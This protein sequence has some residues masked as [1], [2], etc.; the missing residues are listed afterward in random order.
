MNSY[1]RTAI[2][3]AAGPELPR[4]LNRF[5]GSTVDPDTGCWLWDGATTV[6]YGRIK[7]NS[8]IDMAHRVSYEIFVGPIPEGLQ[9]DHLCRNRACVNPAHLEPVTRR[10][11]ILRGTA[12]TAVNARK[13]HCLNGHDLAESLVS[14]GHRYCRTCANT[15]RNAARTAKRVAA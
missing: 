15:R 4:L 14:N 1:T 9:L 2:A 7:R 3:L 13:T 11:N 8:R 6:G 5:L 12:P 10:E